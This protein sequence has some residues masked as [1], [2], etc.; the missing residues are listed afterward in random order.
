MSWTDKAGPDRVNMSRAY[1]LTRIRQSIN[2]LRRR[3]IVDG[4]GVMAENKRGESSRGS[5]MED[6]ST[7][8]GST[9]SSETGLRLPIYVK[10]EETL[11]I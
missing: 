3:H 11:E 6:D 2:Y 1:S 7:P 9:L 10:G 8:E 4:Q 5:K